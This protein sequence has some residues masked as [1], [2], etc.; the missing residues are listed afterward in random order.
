MRLE[1]RSEVNLEAKGFLIPSPVF[2]RRE[3]RKRQAERQ[4]SMERT[5]PEMESNFGVLA[6]A[7]QVISP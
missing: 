6:V 1:T 2:K 3:E 7:V 4:Y 5:P